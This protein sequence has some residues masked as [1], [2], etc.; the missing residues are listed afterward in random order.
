MAESSL[1]PS[2][3]AEQVAADLEKSL[4]Q[5]KVPAVTRFFLSCLGGA[6][7]IVGGVISGAGNAW[8]ENDQSR[9]N[10][11]LEQWLKLQEA[12]IKEIG[13]TLI[14]IMMRLN[15]QDDATL[16]RIESPEYLSLVRKAFRD[17]SAAES[18]EKREL[19]RNL[20]CHA[21]EDR[22]CE[23]DIVRLFIKW[24]AEYTEL[25]FKVIKYIYLHEGSTR[26][27]I[28]EDLHGRPVREDAPEADLFKLLIQDLSMGHIVRQQR[29]IDMHGNFLK[30][31]PGTNRSRA[32]SRTVVSAFEDGK[33]YVLTALGK[34]FVFYTMNEVIPKL[35]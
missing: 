4:S 32:A 2:P 11:L 18:E 19:I 9:V 33:P 7:P 16:K 30:A 5:G 20:L 28:W 1:Q 22:L 15:V 12:E 23:D 29:E 13:I 8:S 3:D 14:E 21:A 17:W 27:E 6:I 25:H 31:R 10:H 24:I 35:S 34:Q 26:A